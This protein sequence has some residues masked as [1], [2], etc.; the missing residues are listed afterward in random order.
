MGGAKRNIKIVR[1]A[2]RPAKKMLRAILFLLYDIFRQ[3]AK[4]FGGAVRER[5][6]WVSQPQQLTCWY[7]LRD[8]K[9]DIEMTTEKDL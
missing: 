6:G 4:Y 1:A 5:G 3:M 8:A 2:F 7:A 9:R